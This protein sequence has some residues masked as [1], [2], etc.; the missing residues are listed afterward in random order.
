MA[1]STPRRLSEAVGA[2]LHLEY[3]CYRAGLFSEN[4]LKS[5]VGQV[6]SSIPIKSSGVRVHADYPH[7]A[8]NPQRITKAKSVDFAL[9][10][11]TDPLDTQPAEIL[12]ETKWAGSSHCSGQEIF[13]D[14]LRLAILKR[15]VPDATCLFLLAG[16]VDDIEKCLEKFPF[17]TGGKNT[18]I[19]KKPG[20]QARL[21]LSR[22]PTAFAT[23][24]S[25]KV[26]GLT[27]SGCAIPSG[28]TT[29]PYATFPEINVKREMKFHVKVWEICSVDAADIDPAV[30]PPAALIRVRRPPTRARRAVPAVP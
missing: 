21:E 25:L 5:A 18:G 19:T 22:V 11:L 23:R 3:C 20:T 15:A 7:S 14:F 24:A 30:W 2:W 27:A 10:L 13:N 4:S 6:L 1:L 16:H 29:Q 9:T 17:A 28:L 8:L 12:V 26:A